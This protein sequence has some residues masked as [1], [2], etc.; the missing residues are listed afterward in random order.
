MLMGSQKDVKF[1]QQQKDR[2]ISTI[3][4]VSEIFSLVINMSTIRCLI[5]LDTS[6]KWKLFHF[7]V[8]NAIL[9]GDLQKEVYMRVPEG[10]SY[11]S[12]MV[13]R[14]RISLYGLRQSSIKR[15]KIFCCKLLNI[16]FFLSKYNYS[17]FIHKFGSDITIL[18]VYVDETIITQSCVPHITSVK[19]LLHTSF[20]IEDLGVLQQFFCIEITYFP[21]G[22]VMS[23]KK[24]TQDLLQNC[25][26]DLSIKAVIPLP[27]HLKFQADDG[28][29]LSNLELYR[30]LIGKLIF[31]D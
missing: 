12:N 6:R 27:Y 26:F 5:S 18:V 23:Q 24:F 8:N 28:D 20:S 25:N 9:Y 30:S 15:F 16:R 3:L 29:L 19:Q 1:I 2:I 10:I 17:L 14:L 11:P 21:E 7:D 4:I 31:Y 22:I 13:C